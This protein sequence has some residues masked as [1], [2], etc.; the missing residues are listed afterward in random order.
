MIGPC[1]RSRPAIAV[2]GS[3]QE[4]YDSRAGIQRGGRPMAIARIGTAL[5]ALAVGGGAPA[6]GEDWPSRTIRLIVPFPPGG[7]TDLGARLVGNFL[8]QALH[9]Q[10]IVENRSGADGNIGMEAAA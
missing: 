2:A 10:V 8:S 5:L 7:S 3:G 1:W 4:R 9:A 6:R